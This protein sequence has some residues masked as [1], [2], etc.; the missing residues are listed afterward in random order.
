MELFYD[1]IKKTR[2]DKK[3][4]KSSPPIRICIQIDVMVMYLKR[5]WPICRLF[6]QRNS[7]QTSQNG[8]KS[9]FVC[10]DQY[11]IDAFFQDAKMVLKPKTGI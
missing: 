9:I 5:S 6:S 3:Y 1:L 8:P 10:F 2:V 11:T 7:Q 4:S